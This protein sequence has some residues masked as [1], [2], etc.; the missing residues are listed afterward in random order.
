[1]AQLALARSLYD[2]PEAVR[3][4]MRVAALRQ[5]CAAIESN[6]TNIESQNR[7]LSDLR[8]ELSARREELANAINEGATLILAMLSAQQ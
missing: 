6:I 2:S 3:I 8:A 4:N 7:A 5:E 1:M